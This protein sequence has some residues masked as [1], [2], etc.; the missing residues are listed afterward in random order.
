MY[1][2]ITLIP[3]LIFSLVLLTLGFPEENNAQSGPFVR[4]IAATIQD[5]KVILHWVDPPDG[6]GPVYI[7]RKIK[8]AREKNILEQEPVQI[9]RGVQSYIE[10]IEADGIYS[11]LVLASN[12]G[13]VPYRVTIPNSNYIE[14]EVKKTPV[15]F[16]TSATKYQNISS[17]LPEIKND[18]IILSFT[19]NGSETTSN[20]PLVLYRST[21]PIRHVQDLVQAV[22]VQGGIIESPF[23]DYPVPNIPYYYALV[24]EDDIKQGTLKLEVGKNITIVPVEVTAGT[25]RIGLPGPQSDIRSLPLPTLSITATV[26]SIYNNIFLPTAIQPLSPESAKVVS[27]LPFIEQNQK[28]LKK[29][30]VFSQDLNTSGGGEE[31]TLRTI[32]QGPFNNRDWNTVIEQLVRFISLPRSTSIEARSRFYLGQAYYMTGKYRE[33]LFEF[34]LMKNTYPT[35]AREWIQSILPLLGD[36]GM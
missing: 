18:S 27:M 6:S 31:F 34:L 23:I 4:Q 20:R 1:F 22:I 33:A 30:R 32:V 11:Y 24:F 21:Q 28:S 12:A 5:D 15:L 7:Y 35:E 26:P 17:L 19:L 16:S 29:P 14:L 10:P 8:Q 2:R 25:F 3:I 13:E 36:E 9:P